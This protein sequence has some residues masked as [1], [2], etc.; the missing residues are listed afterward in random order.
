MRDLR[1][2]GGI[3]RTSGLR[4]YPIHSNVSIKVVYVSPD[5][6]DGRRSLDEAIEVFHN[7]E[8]A[9]FSTE[10]AH[11]VAED[12]EAALLRVARLDGSDPM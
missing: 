8:V 12:A 6:D 3:I 1:E 10:D 9:A 5:N 2:H 4:E 11:L 7:L